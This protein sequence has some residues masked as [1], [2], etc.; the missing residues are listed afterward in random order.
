MNAGNQ[1]A[2]LRR[3]PWER[4]GFYL[5]AAW[6]GAMI[7]LC[8]HLPLLDLPQ[9]AAQARLMQD[10]LDGSSPWG[11]L[12]RVN[13]FTP[14]ALEYLLALVLRFLPIHVAFALLLELAYLGMLG[15]C[16]ALRRSL[17]GDAR[18]DLL[19]VP[20]FFG[21]SWAFGFVP[22]LLAAPLGMAFMGSARSHACAPSWRTGLGLA[23][24][25]ILVFFAHG[26]TFAFALLAGAA[27]TA[28]AVRQDRRLRWI[29]LAPYLPLV[30]LALSYQL[31]AQRAPGSLSSQALVWGL[32]PVDRLES[33][34]VL[35][36]GLWR[37]DKGFALLT[38]LLL[39]APWLLGCRPNRGVFGWWVPFTVT[40]LVFFLLPQKGLDADY[41]YQ[42]FSIFV[43]PAYALG[44]RPGGGGQGRRLR[45]LLTGTLLLACGLYLGIRSVRLHRFARES[46][47]IDALLETLP[48]GKRVLGL[49]VDSRSDAAGEA[50][51]Y[52][53]YLAW[54]QAYR[55][56][57]VD[58][59]FAAYHAQVVRFRP[60]CG[61][62]VP[63]GMEYRPGRFQ[64]QA[65]QAWIYDYIIVKG[66]SPLAQ[67]LVGRVTGDPGC[68]FVLLT[69]VADWQVFAR[70]V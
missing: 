1:H 68:P 70:H 51:V 31:L 44:F 26:L 18:L 11:H 57:F 25:G 45:T 33:L 67:E 50:D 47:A 53:H 60:G 7:W 14:Y 40:A 36:L 58:V 48:P 52:T 23:A 59:N 10:L 46:A 43:L 30:A 27:F 35:P 6:G 63:A 19:F 61:P 37:D 54:Y 62:A 22:F 66:R 3:Q 32:A 65:H 34:L 24:L 9:H 29:Q 49:V 5:L 38:L 55:H 12:V 39:A 8:P 69:A 41:I 21:F 13:L 4:M 15:A 56:G 2:A 42:R 28:A 16:L 64:F 20:G 17:R